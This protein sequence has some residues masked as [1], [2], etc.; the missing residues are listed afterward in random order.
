MLISTPGV[1]A[2]ELGQDIEADVRAAQADDEVAAVEPRGAVEDP[3]HVLEQDLGPSGSTVQLAAECRQ[4]GAG[5][6]AREQ[7]GA[8]SLL[9]A[10]DLRGD[11]GLADSQEFRGAG[12]AAGQRDRVEGP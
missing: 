4:L 10:A 2:H 8:A 3:A 9:K 11:G 1:Q 7:A 5:R 6:A 12:E